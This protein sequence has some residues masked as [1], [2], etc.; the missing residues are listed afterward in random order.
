MEGAGSTDLERVYRAHAPAAFR[1]ARR[2][3]GSA[4]EAEE[5]VQELFEA[6]AVDPDPLARTASLT[7]W[8]YTT[9]TNRCINRIRDKNN[10]LRL[11]REHMDPIPSRAASVEDAIV[12]G[13]LL[14]GLPEDLAKVAV[15]Y[16][17]DEM[18]HDE[19]A[20]LLGCSRRHVGN[21]LE[22]LHETVRAGA[23]PS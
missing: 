19:I 8:F 11:L 23:E 17:A 6:L 2:I 12:L 18:T 5:V 16:Y 1:R 14:S 7:A 20:K 15:Y 4:H 21:L 10:R 9:T 13:E 22:R 3:L